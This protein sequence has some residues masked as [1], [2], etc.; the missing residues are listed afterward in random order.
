MPFLYWLG[1][2]ILLVGQVIAAA[3]LRHVVAELVQA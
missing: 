2:A 3:L 1:E